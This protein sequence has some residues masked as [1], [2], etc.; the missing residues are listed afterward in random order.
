MARQNSN[1]GNSRAGAKTWAPGLDAAGRPAGLLLPDGVANAAGWLRGLVSQWAAAEVAP[2]RL[3]PWLPVAFGFGVVVYFTA[4][5]EPAWWASS[6][7]ALG[8][9]SVTFLARRRPIAF[10]LSL[11]FAAC[12]AGLAIATVQSARIAHPILQFPLSSVSVAG[13]VEIREERERSD[14]I[15]VRVQRFDEARA[16]PVPN[17]V[18]VAVRKGGAPAVGS[19][20]E[21]KA[22]LSPPLQPLRPG[23]YDFARDM[24]F[25]RIGASGYALGAVKVATP[26]FTGGFWLRYATIIDDL[27]ETIDKRIR[28]VIPGDNG[29]IASAL[30]TGKRDAI[31][32]PVNDAMYVSSLAHVLSISGYH[33]AVVAGIV[34]FVIRAGLAL[35]PLLANRHPIKKWAAFGALIAAT[36]YLLLSGAEVA[37]QR[38]FIMIAIVLVGVMLDRPTLTFRTLAVAAIA[39]LVLAPQAVVHP[40]FQMSFAATLALIA[41]YQHGLPWHADRD[42]SLGLRMALWGVRE[43]AG[44][45]LASLVAGLATTPYAAYHFHRLAPYGTLANLLAMPVVSAAVMPMGILGVVAM[46]FGYDSIFWR[47]MGDGI[48]WMIW[49]SL[50]VANLPGAVGRMQAFGTGPLLAGTAGLLIVCLLRTPL[51]WSGAVVALAAGLWAVFTP[52]ADVLVAGDGQAAAFRGA[53]GRLAVLHS[54]RDSFAIK[55]WLAA[56][57]DARLPKDPSLANGVTCDA[58]GCIGKLSDGRLISM[59]L[60]LEA[61]A[62]DCT[63]AA[64]V[65]SV[66]EAMSPNCV[67]ALVDRNVWRTRGAVALRWM[68]DRFEQT[69]TLPPD[70]DRPWGHGSPEAAKDTR[71]SPS[72]GSGDVTPR[73][74]ALEADD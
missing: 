70:Y 10:P 47:L 35:I 12:T 17:R 38:S 28:A 50:W 4:D 33:M 9:I 32:T 59:A 54:G 53:D 72:L 51:R 1:R 69:V 11:G 45:I 18:R 71:L 24:Y 25:Q 22:H 40:S 65:V 68:G 67:A 16:A 41:A 44:L 56:D 30:I 27:R 2:G 39:V 58:I 5:H 52:R 36:F 74:D 13:F 23:G 60:A 57:A 46:P 49:V 61:L 55:E 42:S 26:P 63:R 34:F 21:F 48:D 6:M 73:P 20:V 66:R 37:T 8:G 62:E 31:S 19:F 29:S 15:V 64:V 3:M 43:F 14:R 7:L